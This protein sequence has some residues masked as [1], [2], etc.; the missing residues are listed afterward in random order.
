LLGIA[1]LCGVH[2][3]YYKKAG[4]VKALTKFSYI[5]LL[6]YVVFS[7]VEIIL[8]L[9]VVGYQKYCKSLNPEHPSYKEYCYPFAR[10]GI[11]FALGVIVGVS[12][13]DYEK[14][15]SFFLLMKI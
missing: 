9:N 11:T 8:L 15:I 3:I 14:I 12:I 7:F 5:S 2:G 10:W 4:E 13:H 6:L 1:A